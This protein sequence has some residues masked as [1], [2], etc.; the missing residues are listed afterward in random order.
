MTD[1]NFYLE[2]I[3]ERALELQAKHQGDLETYRV[4]LSKLLIANAR[5]E[6]ERKE[7]EQMLKIGKLFQRMSQDDAREEVIE[8]VWDRYGFIALLRGHSLPWA[9]PHAT[10]KLIR[11]SMDLLPARFKVVTAMVDRGLDEIGTIYQACGFHFVGVMRQG[12]RR[13]LVTLNG[14]PISERQ[15]GRLAGTRGF[16]ALARLG[17]DASSVSRRSRYFAFRGT[18]GERR[19]L[20]AAISG[21]IKP[22]P[23]R[24][25]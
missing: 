16:R 7:W 12:Q 10:S 2:R 21:L 15:A 8:R 9:H 5:D 19:E 1:R 17:F 3:M 11:R 23:K 18:R 24:K 13:A 14:K 25:A 4:E 20:Q 6:K 22:Y